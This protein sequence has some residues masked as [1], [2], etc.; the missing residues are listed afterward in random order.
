MARGGAGTD[1]HVLGLAI[2]PVPEVPADGEGAQEQCRQLRS[3]HF[4]RPARRAGGANREG[5][6]VTGGDGAAQE[7]RS[8]ILNV[9]P[10]EQRD[11]AI[12]MQ[13]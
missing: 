13:G 2:A 10:A 7:R 4:D 11:L 6:A 5:S 1:V 12:E 8:G 3:T 9:G